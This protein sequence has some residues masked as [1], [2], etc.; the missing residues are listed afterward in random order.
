MLYQP[1]IYTKNDRIFRAKNT[2]SVRIE[3]NYSPVVCLEGLRKA[4]KWSPF[5][6][7]IRYITAD[8]VRIQL[9]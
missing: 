1:S 7:S 4:V 6:I 5:R 8:G 2:E 3:F 9:R